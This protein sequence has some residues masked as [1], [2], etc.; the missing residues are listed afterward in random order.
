MS[1][2]RVARGASGRGQLSDKEQRFVAEYLRDANATRAATAA[3]YSVRSAS[4]IGW[5][6]LQKTRVSDAIERGRSRLLQ[7]AEKTAQDIIDRLVVLGFSDISDV[8]EWNGETGRVKPFSEADTRPIA[9]FSVTKTT[10]ITKDGTEIINEHAK[11]K[12]DDRRQALKQLAEL[13]GI[14][15]KEGGGAAGDA[16]VCKA[17]LAEDWDAIPS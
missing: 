16:P 3:G 5:E 9:E 1:T 10:T 13:L 11:V 7:R 2:D 14:G 15:P 4:K 17:Y 12:L 8:A 6:L